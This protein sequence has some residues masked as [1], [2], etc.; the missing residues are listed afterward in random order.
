MCE[1]DAYTSPNNDINQPNSSGDLRSPTELVVGGVNTPLPIYTFIHIPKCGGSPVE[2]Y[3]EQHYSDRIFGTTHKW[4]CTKDNNPIVIIREPIERFISLYH[5]W[6]NGSHGRNSRNQEFIDKY[7]NYTISDFIRTFKSCVPAIKGNYM[8]ELSVGFTWR[9]H[10][11]KQVYWIPPECFANSI[12]ILYNHDLNEKIHQVLD[13]IGVEDKCIPLEK[14]NTTRKKNGEEVVIS[15]EDMA[16]L[17][18]WFKEDF[19]LWEAAQHLPQLF[20]KVI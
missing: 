8:H 5:Y 18:E 19:I 4:L 16:W 10:F 13:Y 15:D 1:L 20:K 2:N 12:V 7:G 14:N 6:K 3:F 11:F 17:K 9:V